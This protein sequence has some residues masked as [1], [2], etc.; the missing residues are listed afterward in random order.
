MPTTTTS[1]VEAAV[2]RITPEIAEDWLG[3][4]SH[5]RTLRNRHVTTLAGAMSRGEWVV[6]GDAIRFAADGTLLDGQHRLWAIIEAETAIDSLVIRGLPNEAQETMDAGA[7]RNLADA[8]KLRGETNALNLASIVT[9]HWRMDQGQV[10]TVSTR[11][12]VQQAIAHLDRH[13]ALR[14]FVGLA[15]SMNSRLRLS[16]AMV[17]AVAYQLD[18]IDGDSAAEFWRRL[19]SGAGLDEGSPILHL[20]RYLETQALATTGR[21]GG[22]STSVVTVHA[23]IIKAWNHWRGGEEIGRLLWRSTGTNAEAFPVPR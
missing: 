10:R 18:S 21:G 6:N 19:D 1:P 13:P 8:L 11:P 14:D 20:R 17:G 4:N 23:L 3:R 9:Y 12:T 5:N 16:A 22:R 7:R 2:E 15:R